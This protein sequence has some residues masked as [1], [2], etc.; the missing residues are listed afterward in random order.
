MT[1]VLALPGLGVIL[2]ENVLGRRPAV[3]DGTA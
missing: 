2:W 1:I 3:T